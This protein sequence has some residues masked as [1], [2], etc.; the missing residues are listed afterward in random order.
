MEA[1]QILLELNPI[2]REIFN[3]QSINLTLNTNASDIDEWDSL[4]HAIMVSK[5]EKY[6]KIK[7]ELMEMLNF[8]NVGNMVDVIE[9]KLNR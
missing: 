1:N 5:V 8:K 2:F 4:N 7:F 3:D 9:K 6:F